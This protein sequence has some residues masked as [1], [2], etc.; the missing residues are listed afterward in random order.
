MPKRDDLAGRRFTHLVAE[1]F[2]GMDSSGRALW[3]CRCDCGNT[4]IVP[5]SKLKSGDYKSCGCMHHKYGHGQSDTRIY[6][7]WRT[8]K[9]RC[10]DSNSHKYHAYGG[11]GIKVCDEWLNSFE[12]FYE[13]AMANGYQEDLSIDRIDNDG[14]YCPENCRWVTQK[15]QANNTRKNRLLTHNGETH[16][17]AEWATIVGITKAALYHR[18]SRGWSVKEALTTPMLQAAR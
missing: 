17:V 7:I 12:S 11:R 14:D 5:G 18:L 2:T 15:E 10:V 13:W 9:A 3:L 6:H 1:E 16:T 8:M 4:K